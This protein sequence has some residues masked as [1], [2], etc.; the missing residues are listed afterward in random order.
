MASAAA[1]SAATL[2]TLL[3]GNSPDKIGR[4]AFLY[5]PQGEKSLSEAERAELKRLRN[6][7]RRAIEEKISE[8]FV[9]FTAMATAI[10]NEVP[11]KPKLP[12]L[13]ISA[14]TVVGIAAATAVAAFRGKQ[15][16][17]NPPAIGDTASGE[18]A[19]EPS[20]SV[21]EPTQEQRADYLALVGMIQGHTR[22]G[23]HTNVLVSVKELLPHGRRGDCGRRGHHHIPI[24]PEP[25]N[26][27]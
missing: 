27:L 11:A 4:S 15:A 21:P 3:T 7:I 20:E 9:D 25:P 16:E 22:D 10:R 13:L 23:N 19:P 2:Y 5:P 1:E 8:R 12:R 24:H 6:V 14:L 26:F 17:L 18:S